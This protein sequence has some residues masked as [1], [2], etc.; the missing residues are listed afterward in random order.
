MHRPESLLNN[1]FVRNTAAYGKNYASYPTMLT[2]LNVS[3]QWTKPLV[4]G[5]I[6]DDDLVIGL[7][8]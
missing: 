3:T 6:V 1:T 2:I 7:L 8:D 5:Q 4:S